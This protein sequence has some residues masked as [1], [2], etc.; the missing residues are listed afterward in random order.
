MY[1]ERT[2]KR[3]TAS[4]GGGY[5]NLVSMLLILLHLIR[6]FIHVYSSRIAQSRTAPRTPSRF[7]RSIP[8]AVSWRAGCRRVIICFTLRAFIIN[9]SASLHRNGRDFA[10]QQQPESMVHEEAKHAMILF[11]RCW[12]MLTPVICSL[13]GGVD[14]R[15]RRDS[16]VNI[17]MIAL[18]GAGRIIP[19]ASTHCF[20]SIPRRERSN[21]YCDGLRPV[22]SADQASHGMSQAD[23]SKYFVG[24]A[25][26]SHQHSLACTARIV[27]V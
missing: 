6:T 9:A 8:V 7:R 4:V 26:K 14:E 2:M 23:V 19:P 17:Q 22:V 15:C 3:T 10:N 1:A 13:A 11:R 20:F 12:K 24:L 27:A 18:M 25:R 16:A 5:I 21:A